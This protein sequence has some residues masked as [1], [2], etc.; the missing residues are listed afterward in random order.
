M[1]GDIPN[2]RVGDDRDFLNVLVVIPDEAKVGYHR[3]ETVPARECR[4]VDNEA[5]KIASR[6]DLGSTA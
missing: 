1:L 6:L 4:G 3:T 5:G 2:M